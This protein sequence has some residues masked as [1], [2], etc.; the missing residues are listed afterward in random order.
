MM[1][2]AIRVRTYLVDSADIASLGDDG[3]GGELALFELGPLGVI[4]RLR[5][6][7]PNGGVLVAR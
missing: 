1:H 3:F 6:V 5:A 2:R 7:I 4:F